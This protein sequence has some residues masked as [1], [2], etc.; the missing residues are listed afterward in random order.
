LVTFARTIQRGAYNAPSWS[1]FQTALASAVTARDQDY[2]TSLPADASLGAAKN[3]LM[4]AIS[5]LSTTV[6][7]VES[8][9]DQ[10]AGQFRLLQNY[11]NPF[12]P[13]TAISYQLS[14]VSFVR[15]GVY[16]AL[17][18]ELTTLVN[19]TQPAGSYVVHWDATSHPSGVYYYRIIAGSV[20]QTR[21][22]VLAR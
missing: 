5:G 12:N 21:K 14:V 4:S 15:L 10:I 7:A 22:M 17:G 13:S 8:E 11:P 1:A 18:R 20:T 19:D 16:D 2:T 3:S 6:S 9:S